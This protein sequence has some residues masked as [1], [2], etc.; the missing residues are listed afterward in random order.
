MSITTPPRSTDHAH[1]SGRGFSFRRPLAQQAEVVGGAVTQSTKSTM[2]QFPPGSR[3][4]VSAPGTLSFF[5]IILYSSQQGHIVPYYLTRL[6]GFA[7]T[8]SFGKSGINLSHKQQAAPPTLKTWQATLKTWQARAPNRKP[9]AAIN[10][11]RASKRAGHL[12]QDY[13]YHTSCSL[14]MYGFS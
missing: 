5:P 12:L 9:A 11:S 6:P 7:K 14:S 8:S 10:G 3:I 2:I 1:L 4:S 13:G